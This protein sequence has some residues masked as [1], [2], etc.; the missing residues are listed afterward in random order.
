MGRSN[1]ALTGTFQHRRRSDPA[2][3]DHDL[4]SPEVI[5]DLH[6]GVDRP[7]CAQLNCGKYTDCMKAVRYRNLRMVERMRERR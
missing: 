2:R 3:N 6:P 4:C 1:A 7:P 5:A